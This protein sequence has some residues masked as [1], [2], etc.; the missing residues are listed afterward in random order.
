MLTLLTL[1][2]LGMRMRVR[3]SSARRLFDATA[4]KELPFL[5]SCLYF[6]LAFL[7]AYIPTFYIQVLG[8]KDDVVSN[9]L[10][11][12]LVPLLNFGSFFGRIVSCQDTLGCVI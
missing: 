1:P 2:V 10:A 12:Y 9:Q 11:V 6:L 7:G 4:L 3:P 5:L 8:I